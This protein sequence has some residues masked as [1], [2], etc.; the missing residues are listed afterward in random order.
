MYKELLDLLVCPKSG[1]S[2]E[3][4]NANWN[5]NW[6]V[7][8]GALVNEEQTCVYQIV[9]GI[10]RFVETS[11]YADNFG[12][13]WNKFKSLQLDSCSGL[14]ISHDR[15]WG[16][17]KWDRRQIEGKWILDAGCGSGRFAEIALNAGANVVALD[18]STAVDA[19]YKNLGHHKNLH[20]VQGDIYC[21]P[22]KDQ[23]FDFIYSLGVL[24]HT[25]NVE[26]AFK[27][28]PAKL[29][30]EGQLCVDYYWKRFRTMLNA[31]YLVRPLVRNLSNEQ[32]LVLV[33]KYTP[34][35][36]RINSIFLKI[37][38]IGTF[39]RRLVPVADYRGIFPFT[40]EQVKQIAILDTF[41]ML[42]P[43][44][45]KPQR[46]T[47]VRKWFQDI[48][49]EDIKVSHVAHLVAKGTKPK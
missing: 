28:L 48:G 25:P 13:Q 40:Q 32:L 22:F 33:E 21:L 12:L 23:S 43:A 9:E 20:L 1:E 30:K 15:F 35:M 38:L 24:Q 41:D 4:I 16:A 47:T 45:D 27:S 17:T 3:L 34:L 29:K 42:S 18:F 37:P 46:K 49:F 6:E 11:N 36:L 10:P 44:Y 39:L 31:K 19:C 8:S 26:V 5:S 14:N 7:M 2:L